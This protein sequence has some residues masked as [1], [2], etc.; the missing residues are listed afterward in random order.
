MKEKTLEI[1]I[2]VRYSDFDIEITDAESGDFTN[3]LGYDDDSHPTLGNDLAYEIE[4]WVD[5]LKGDMA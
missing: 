4:F 3:I 1:R 2:K 5:A